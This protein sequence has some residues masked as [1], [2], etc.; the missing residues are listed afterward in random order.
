MHSNEKQ[1]IVKRKAE[2]YYTMNLSCH[3]K[4]KPSGFR[5]GL[6]ISEFI[7]AGSYYMFLDTR[8]PTQQFRLFIDEIFDIE[9]YVEE[10]P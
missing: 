3:V 6:I 1:E 4:L 8:Y 9:D 10:K 2:F 5:N 7:E